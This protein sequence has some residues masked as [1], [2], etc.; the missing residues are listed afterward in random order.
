MSI[1]AAAA[2]HR[3]HPLPVPEVCPYGCRPG[4]VSLSWGSQLETPRQCLHG[5]YHQPGQCPEANAGPAALA[6]TLSDPFVATEMHCPSAEP[7]EDLVVAR[8]RSGWI[9]DFDDIEAGVAAA[10]ECGICGGRLSYVALRPGDG[11]PGTSWG[12]C[13][14]CRH[15][16]QL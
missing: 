7:L 12:I 6:P 9:P 15:W 10:L 3:V 8:Q 5:A 16:V 4:A 2:S 1:S 13:V 11:I 14:T